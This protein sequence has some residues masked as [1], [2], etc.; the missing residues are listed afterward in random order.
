MGKGIIQTPELDETKGFQCLGHSNWT[1]CSRGLIHSER[2]EFFPNFRNGQFGGFSLLGAYKLDHLQPFK[3]I[4]F[5]QFSPCLTLGLTFIMGSQSFLPQGLKTRPIRLFELNWGYVTWF[6]RVMACLPN[7][8]WSI[9]T[10]WPLQTGT[11]TLFFAIRHQSQIQLWNAFLSWLPY[12][13]QVSYPNYLCW[14]AFTQLWTHIFAILAYVF[15]RRFLT[16]HIFPLWNPD[17]LRSGESSRSCSRSPFRQ[18]STL[19]HWANAFP[20]TSSYR[21]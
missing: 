21:V 14:S 19:T 2:R 15:D 5:R 20:F 10:F 1:I 12:S 17:V 7:D 6:R 4:L 16:R 13:C 11:A 18:L 8:E 3:P 9:G